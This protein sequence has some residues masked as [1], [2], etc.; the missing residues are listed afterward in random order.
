MTV[1]NYE[2]VIAK[3]FIPDFFS[4]VQHRQKEGG[5][6]GMNDELLQIIS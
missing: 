3:L 1:N 4:T 6:W 5:G 2:V